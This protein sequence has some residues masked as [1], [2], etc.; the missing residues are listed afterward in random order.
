MSGTAGG[1]H[2]LYQTKQGKLFSTGACGLGWCRNLPLTSNL[3]AFRPI[4]FSKDDSVRL[5]HASYYHNLAVGAQ[6]GNLYAWGCGTF[7]DPGTM[8]GVIPA[9]GPNAQQQDLG[10][11]PMVVPMD[12]KETVIDITGGAYHSAVLTQTGR[13]LTWGAAQLGQ[14]GRPIPTK[15]E[16]GDY[17]HSD[18]SG[19]PVDPIPRPARGIP[20]SEKVRALGAGFYNTFALCQS[21]KVYCTG[22]NQNE[23]CGKTGPANLHQLTLVKELQD[24]TIDQ[25]Q[26][27]YCHT[28]AL[29]FDGLVHSLGCGDDGQ[30]GDGQDGDFEARPTV[31]KVTLPNNLRACKVAAGANHSVVLGE[32]GVAYTF[33]SNDVG[34]CGVPS[35]K[36]NE[37]ERDL[38]LVP[39]PV[40]L[41]SKAGKVVQV[42]AGYA[43][44]VLTTETGKVFVFGQSDS[45]QL[46]LGAD[47]IEQGK[48][49]EPR[50]KPVEIK[51]PS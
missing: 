50:L 27:G 35:G 41:P 38:I 8:D 39:Q 18:S 25:V 23:Q 42:S 37:E 20:A 36:N 2:S 49:V 12:D 21:G 44:T 11:P 5:V 29:T 4:S 13:I 32:N 47:R 10:G 40:N 17:E 24:K 45:G 26:G 14:L 31:T 9:L 1:E 48:D 34:Q 6:T 43:H 15:N 28:L 22:E 7:T 19:L 46:G 33:G 3:F 30:R 51:L 16:K